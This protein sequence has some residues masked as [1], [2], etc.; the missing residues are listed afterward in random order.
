MINSLAV[1]AI[2]TGHQYLTDEA[3]EIWKPE[4]DAEVAFA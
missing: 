1:D 2:E 3:V 4:F